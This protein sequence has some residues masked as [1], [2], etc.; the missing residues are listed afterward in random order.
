MLLSGA[1][2][3]ASIALVL[4]LKT[5]NTMGQI[6]SYADN[7]RYRRENET[8]KWSFQPPVTPQRIGT[9]RCSSTRF[10]DEVSERPGGI[11]RKC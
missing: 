8:R 9:P 1:I 5:S 2:A 11:N 3:V 4:W 6:D 7:F 10:V